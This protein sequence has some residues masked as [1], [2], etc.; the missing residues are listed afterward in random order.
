MLGH[1]F[2][3]DHAGQHFVGV[4]E[5]CG[6]SAGAVDVAALKLTYQLSLAPPYL[7]VGFEGY[8]LCVQCA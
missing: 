2:V 8:G 3:K 4:V 5:K 6:K 1:L 7:V